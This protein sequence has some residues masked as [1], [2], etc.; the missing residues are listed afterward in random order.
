VKDSVLRW[1]LLYLATL[2]LVFAA[3]HAGLR[4]NTSE[5]VPRGFYWISHDPPQ[6]GGY[7]AVCPPQAD[8]FAL[9]RDRG[10][11]GHGR[12]PGGYSPLIKVFAAGPGDHVRIDESG[13]R[14]GK[15]FWPDSAPMPVDA[16]GRR[17]IVPV[18]DRTLDPGSVLL[19]SQDCP[20]GFDAR[21][22]GVLSRSDIVGSVVP[23]LTW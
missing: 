18:F 14:V 12:C 1:L 5:S 23:L 3:G 8:I 19:M 9:A 4:L 21:Y 10:Y 16:E 17:L 22:F 7:V 11:V 13:V 15:R 2:Q 20:T 6:L